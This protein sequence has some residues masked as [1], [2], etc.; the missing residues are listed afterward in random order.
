VDL[1]RQTGEQAFAYI[2]EK[3]G[4]KAEV[5][6]LA[7]KS[8]APEQSDARTQGFREMITRLPGVRIVAEQDAWLPEMA[9]KKAGDIL[10]AHRSLD[11][12]WA[13]NEGGTAGAVMAVKNAGKAKEVAVFGTDTSEQLISFLLSEDEILHA[14]TGQRPFEIG[15][16]AVEAAVRSLKQEPLQ[17]HQLVPGILLSRNDPEGV[18]AYA[19]RLKTL[20]AR[21]GK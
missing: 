2:Q 5:A 13:A 21:G 10:T 3:L 20:I 16:R 18:K 7:F 17:G 14:I 19:E 1:G 11:I 8:Q 6:L 4:G 15:T 12:L 9:I